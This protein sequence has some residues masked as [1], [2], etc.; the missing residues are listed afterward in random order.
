MDILIFLWTFFKYTVLRMIRKKIGIR[1]KKSIV[2][3][4]DLRAQMT[5][6]NAPLRQQ[7]SL[8]KMSSISKIM[9]RWPMALNTIDSRQRFRIN[10]FARVLVMT[11]FAKKRKNK[12]IGHQRELPAMSLLICTTDVY[13]FNFKGI[14]FYGNFK[15]VNR[16]CFINSKWKF[17]EC[18]LIRLRK[19]KNRE[20]LFGQNFL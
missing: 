18:A 6:N 5:K 10:Q 19:V 16:Y 15:T 20:Y 11:C 2:A 13:T 9:V 7:N 8:W 4:V 14:I 12:K 1:K 3:I 17:I